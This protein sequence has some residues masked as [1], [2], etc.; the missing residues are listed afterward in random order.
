MKQELW[1][2]GLLEKHHLHGTENGSVDLMLMYFWDG[3]IHGD[4]ISHAMG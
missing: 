4:Q 1:I 3:K 2:G